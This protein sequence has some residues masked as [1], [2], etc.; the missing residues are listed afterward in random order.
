MNGNWTW[1]ALPMV[2][3]A[4]SAC[5]AR[6]HDDRFHGQ[7]DQMEPYH[8]VIDAGQTLSTKLGEGAGAFIEY[9]PGGSWKVWTSCDTKLTGLLCHFEVNF[10]SRGVISEVE[11][12]DLK[13]TDY[14]QRQGDGSYTL[15]VDTASDSPGLRFMTPPGAIVDMQ[16]TLDGQIDPTYFVWVGDGSV[17]DGAPRSPVLFH[18]D[19]P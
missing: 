7:P 19:Q 3:V 16:L 5:S 2:A 18:P 11:G 13:A 17:H 6:S 12:V 14:W 10:L 15:A 1:L 9:K 4:T 8:A